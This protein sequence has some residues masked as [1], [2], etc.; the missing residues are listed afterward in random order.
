MYEDNFLSKYKTMDKLTADS[1]YLGGGA[2][3]VSKT[4]IYALF[5]KT[6]GIKMIQNIF[7]KTDVPKVHKH[8]QDLKYGVSPHILK[9]TH[10]RGKTVQMGLCTCKIQEKS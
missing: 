9:C 2:G 1:V 5:Q 10:Y 4:I 8:G 6:E 3:F 7:E